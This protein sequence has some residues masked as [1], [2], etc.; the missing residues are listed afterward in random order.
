MRCI[1]RPPARRLIA[2]VE[3]V[4]NATTPSICQT[5][6]KRL[7]VPVLQLHVARCADMLSMVPRPGLLAR[8][9]DAVAQSRCQPPARIAAIFPIF[10]ILV[11]KQAVIV[12]TMACPLKLE[13]MHPGHW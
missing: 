13:W 9:K 2:F 11:K 3:N 4:R 6:V 7:V 10:Q 5:P 1:F 8:K 12:D